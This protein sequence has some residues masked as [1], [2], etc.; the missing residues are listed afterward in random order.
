MLSPIMCGGQVACPDMQ[1][2]VNADEIQ[3]AP[4]HDDVLNDISEACNPLPDTV[5]D[6]DLPEISGDATCEYTAHH[7]KFEVLHAE[8]EMSK[9]CSVE[10]SQGLEWRIAAL[11]QQCDSTAELTQELQLLFTALSQQYDDMVVTFTASGNEMGSDLNV[12]VDIAEELM[13]IKKAVCFMAGVDDLAVILQSG[14]FE[15]VLF[16]KRL[17]RNE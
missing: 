11:V 5:V 9:A 13:M 16:H 3:D 1:A 6:P 7:E 14:K 12:P 17:E 4:T 8:I 2:T 15:G 10:I